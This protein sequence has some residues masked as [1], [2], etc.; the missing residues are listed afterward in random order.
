MLKENKQKLKML[1]LIEILRSESDESHPLL[2]HT[3]IEQLNLLGISCDRRTLYKDITLL[4]EYGYEVMKTTVNRENAYY[5]DDRKFSYAEL[6]ILIDAVQAAA[7]ITDK[8]TIELIDKISSLGGEYKSELLKTNIVC[9]NKRKHT[10][11]QIYYNVELLESAIRNRKKV[12]FLYFDLNEN[13]EK[14]YRKN[15]Q[16]YIVE[17]NEISE[18]QSML[19]HLSRK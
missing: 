7:F 18:I 5:I 3:L 12:S 15:K 19:M 14:I 11:E 8:K 1:K 13:K 6:K 4:N 9:F 2:T 17:P 10:N 16:R